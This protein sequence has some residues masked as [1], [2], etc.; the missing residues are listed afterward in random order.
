VIFDA[1]AFDDPL[2][3]PL[4][5]ADG[6]PFADADSFVGV[7]PLTYADDDD[8]DVYADDLPPALPPPDT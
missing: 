7:F 1:G 2:A 4:A 6:D 8:D 3:A 5:N